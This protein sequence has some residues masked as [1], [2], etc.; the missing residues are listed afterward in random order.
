[1]FA[2][3]KSP[4]KFIAALGATA[5]LTVA[6]TASAEEFVSNGRT[7]EVRYHD[8][9]LSQKADQK[10]LDGRIYRAASRVCDTYKDLG[11]LSACRSQAIEH[12]K[13]PIAAAIAK[14]ET[15][16][17]YADARGKTDVTIGH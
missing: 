11:L 8:L 14:A 10:V 15:G 5:L 17:R 3:A 6:G 7:F 1:M 16:E 4:L 2:P 13:A 9:D 12:V